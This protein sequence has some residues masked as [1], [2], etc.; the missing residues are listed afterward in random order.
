MSEQSKSQLR[1]ENNSSFPNNNTGFITPD[2]LRTFNENVIDSTV[3]QTEY[4]ADSASFDSRISA[5]GTPDTGSLLETASFDNGTRNLTFTKGDASTFDVNIPDSQID[6]GSFATT[7]SNTFNGN[8]VV[9]GN[10]TASRFLANNSAHIDGTLR[11]DNDTTMYGDLSIISA[12]PNLKLRDTSGGGFSSGYD[13]RVDT[14]SFEIYDDTHNR[15]VLS[16]VFNTSTSKHT[17][18]LTSEIIVIS[19]SDS[20]TILGDLTASLQE[21]YAWVGNSNT[22]AQAV[23]TSSFAGGVP[24]GTATTGSNTFTGNQTI[25]STSDKSGVIFKTGSSELFVG[26]N[27][28]ERLVISSSTVENYIEINPSSDFMEIY[29][30]PNFNNQST[31]RADI[32]VRNV[33]TDGGAPYNLGYKFDIGEFTASIDD[34]YVLVGDANNRSYQVPTSSFAG[35]GSD[36]TSLNAFTASQETKNT[37]LETYT[38][39]VDNDIANLESFTSSQELL[40]STYATTGSNTFEGNQTF[41]VG[42]G[43]FALKATFNN[44]FFY[45][46]GSANTVGILKN[47]Y[48]EATSMA[49]GT[50]FNTYNSAADVGLTP[51][52]NTVTSQGD[53]NPG[54][55][56]YSG[57]VAQD[58]IALPK[59]SWDN[60]GEVEFKTPIKSADTTVTGN[61]LVSG[62]TTTI[63]SSVSQEGD[64]TING[65]VLSTFGAPGNNSQIDLLTITGS[66]D[67][68]G[69]TYD[70]FTAG[71]QDWPSYGASYVDSF[72]I[73]KF[74]SL[75]YNFG[76]TMLVS[77]PRA[78]LATTVSGSGNIATISARENGTEAQALIA[79]DR[80]DIIASAGKNTIS[81]SV[82]MNS[83]LTASLQEGYVW[84]GD[85]SGRTTTVSTG[86]FGGGGA[87]FPY[88]GDA[89]I[90]GSLGVTGSMSGYVNSLS[91]ASNTASVDFTDGNMFTLTLASSAETH[92][93][94]T[95]IK[96]GQTINI[97][98]TQPSTSG[99]VT[100]AP[101]VL[102]AGGADYQAT[103]TGSAI[104][105]LTLVSLDGTNVLATSIKNFQ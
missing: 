46:L 26:I 66:T 1:S 34:G 11:V 16:D 88:D 69:R 94:P 59:K 83:T 22:I 70:V 49:Q 81:G 9:N 67:N 29:G 13:L 14:G 65:K 41:N 40:N 97:Q 35:G 36:L 58:V 89:Q 31:F 95:N 37:T 27:E 93:N 23:A 21:G 54:I 103:A 44:S 64:Y 38:S 20:V 75:S 50:G 18:S 48:S 12:T 63:S 76:S 72:V 98:I 99:S 105:L 43:A 5:I 68:D 92:I 77:G 84:V 55:Y 61:F 56:A 96:A 85:A 28:S 82:D 79:G 3:N 104:D 91:I 24:E 17:T 71:I 32:T 57:S 102:F 4:T 25:N 87:A 8:Q 52:L 39:S 42:D 30:K 62:S 86:S 33:N 78:T 73:E 15:D 90:S 7:G 74:D 45:T 47:D 60:N 101:S 51:N 19:G 6:T 2:K 100:F 53:D 80:V 10:V